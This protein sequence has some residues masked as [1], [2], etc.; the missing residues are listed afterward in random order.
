MDSVWLP[1]ED[2]FTVDVECVL[3]S[4]TQ[5]PKRDHVLRWLSAIFL[6]REFAQQRRDASRAEDP[7]RV[8]YQGVPGVPPEAFLPAAF[9]EATKRRS[10]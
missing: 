8:M 2:Y 6:L 1:T 5:R 3:A 10:N 9:A 7:A 4:T